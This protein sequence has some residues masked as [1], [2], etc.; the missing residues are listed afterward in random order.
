MVQNLPALECLTRRQRSSELMHSRSFR[1]QQGAGSS[2][3]RHPPLLSRRTQWVQPCLKHLLLWEAWTKV[4]SCQHCCNW[5]EVKSAIREGV[6]DAIGSAAGS[7]A[8]A[9]AAA[10]KGQNNSK[11]GM[12]G[13]ALLGGKTISKLAKSM[14]DSWEFGAERVEVS[15]MLPVAK[16]LEKFA[17]V[18]NSFPG[19]RFLTIYEMVW[20]RKD[21]IVLVRVYFINNSRGLFGLVFLTSWVWVGIGIGIN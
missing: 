7:D 6:D 3:R 12:K 4:A 15:E 21:D 10:I 19:S 9:R 17:E 2:L 16:V 8:E 13:Q 1:Q 11:I 20:T 14:R 5:R 18:P